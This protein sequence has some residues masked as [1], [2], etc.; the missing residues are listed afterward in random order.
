MKHL[1]SAHSIGYRYN[2]RIYH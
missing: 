2:I 1:M